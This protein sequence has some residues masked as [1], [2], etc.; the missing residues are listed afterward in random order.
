MAMILSIIW[1]ELRDQETWILIVNVETMLKTFTI[2]DENVY[3][4]LVCI[5]ER[6]SSGIWG[7]LLVIQSGR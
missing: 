6:I 1:C 7:W 4:D 2:Q 3:I 5:S